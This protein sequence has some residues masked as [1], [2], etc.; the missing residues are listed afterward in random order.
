MQIT[1]KMFQFCT[2]IG[3]KIIIQNLYCFVIMP[4][5]TSKQ[6]SIKPSTKQPTTRRKFKNI[7]LTPASNVEY[8]DVE[9]GGQL[10]IFQLAD[11]PNQSILDNDKPIEKHKVR[12]GGEMVT[13]PRWTRAYGQDY[14]YSGQVASAS[15]FSN[16]G[17]ETIELLLERAKRMSSDINGA[18]VNWYDSDGSI[19]PHHDDEKQLI[20]DQDGFVKWIGMFSLGSNR[21]LVFIPDAQCTDSLVRYVINV[22]HGSVVFMDGR[23]NRNYKHAVLPRPCSIS[24]EYCGKRISVTCRAFKQVKNY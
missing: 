19:G 21:Q 11:A 22:S 24:D 7:I 18:L 8:V 1:T 4:K 5:I 10:C 2:Y 14:V 13:C 16:I 3:A 12:I 23:V 20:L 17:Q 6:Q 9:D 15:D